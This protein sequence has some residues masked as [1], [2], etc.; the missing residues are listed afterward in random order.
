MGTL[1]TS[2]TKLRINNPQNP[3]TKNQHSQKH[4]HSISKKKKK[5]KKKKRRVEEMKIPDQPIGE[6]YL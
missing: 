3:N 5:K 2:Q 6:K 4:C 1:K